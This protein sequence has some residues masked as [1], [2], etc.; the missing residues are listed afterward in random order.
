M[1]K[2]FIE[3]IESLVA[4]SVV[5]LQGLTYTSKPLTLVVVPCA[6]LVKLTTLTGLA[7]LIREKV[8][9]LDVE[10]WLLHVVSHTEVGLIKKTR[11][12]MVVERCWQWDIATMDSRFRSTAS[13]T[14]RHS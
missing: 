6:S 13:S 5:A 4:P 10:Q 12:S 2:E 9:G 14:G 11:I 1:L 7:D 8:D 3:K